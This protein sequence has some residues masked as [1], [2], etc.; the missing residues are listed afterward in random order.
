[1]AKPVGA[2]LCG[3]PYVI[4]ADPT[5]LFDMQHNRWAREVLD[6]IG[7]SAEQLPAL[8]P[9]GAVLGEV[10]PDAA[11]ACGL[12]AGLPVVCGLGDGQAAGLGA[13]ILAA[14]G[15]GLYA[16]VREA[17]AAMSHLLPGA[18][19]PEPQRHARYTRLYEEVYRRLFPALQPYLDRL[20]ELTQSID[21]I[22]ESP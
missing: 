2:S 9:P 19:E 10:T 17:A 4:G 6:A 15:V 8:Y 20:T 11:A 1:M 12:P 3:R 14:A 18:F 5:G 21:A 16:G 13:G 22:E 7:V